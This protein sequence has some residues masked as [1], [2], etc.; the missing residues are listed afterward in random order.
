MRCGLLGERLGH[1]FSKEIHEQLADYTYEL[2]EVA[3]ED[4]DRFMREKA[5]KAINVTIPY[6]QDVIPYLDE[7]SESAKAIGAVNTIVNR[8]GRLFGDNTD[9][10][11]MTQLIRKLGLDLNGKT[12]LILGT[13]GTSRTAQYV[14]RRLGAAV[15]RTKSNGRYSSENSGLRFFFFSSFFKKL[16]E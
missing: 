2:H 9:Q 11:G 6:K 10:I 16:S 5:F 12:V 1:S 7:I 4:L 13:G 14:C 8:D 3:K 15:I